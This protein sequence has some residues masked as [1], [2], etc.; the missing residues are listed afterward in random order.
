MERILKVSYGYL[1]FTFSAMLASAM[2]FSLTGLAIKSPRVGRG[3]LSTRRKHIGA[4]RVNNNTESFTK[5]SIAEWAAF[6]QAAIIFSS[7]NVPEPAGR[8]NMVLTQWI[9]KYDRKASPEEDE[10]SLARK[11]IQR[12][13]DDLERAGFML[14]FISNLPTSD[15]LTSFRKSMSISKIN[16]I[17]P[18]PNVPYTPGS[19]NILMGFIVLQRFVI[20]PENEIEQI[21]K[22]SFDLVKDTTSDP[23]GLPRHRMT[24]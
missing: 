12:H 2:I 11:S 15:F 18:F 21:L 7:M 5:E 10:L 8:V 6:T 17:Q 13:K 9:H 16:I 3:E 4:R 23:S 1:R 22:G 14:A 24:S 19:S 20:N